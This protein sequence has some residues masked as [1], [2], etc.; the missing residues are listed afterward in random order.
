MVVT[1]GARMTCGW[2]RRGYRDW[3]NI[4][5]REATVEEQAAEAVPLTQFGR[6]CVALD[7]Q[8]MPASF[9]QAKGRVAR[10]HGTHQDRLIKK[11]RRLGI[12]DDAA[13]NQSLETTYW[14]A[15]NARFAQPAVAAADFHRATPSARVLDRV[16]RRE[17]TRTVS[18]DWV[19]R[20][21]NRAVQLPRQ[22]GDAPARGR[23]TVCEWEHGRVAIE[24]RGRVMRWTEITG[25]VGRRPVPVLA[26]PAAPPIGRVRKPA[27]TH[28]WRRDSREGAPPLWQAAK[29]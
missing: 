16:F 21:R 20:Y 28:P 8:V 1:V 13:A 2:F 12:A 18:Q 3:K 7:I 11:L 5:V 26:A 17:E 22:S 10:N 19:V 25:A 24:Y 27:A 4:Y 15:H 14:A 29:S 6:M 9:P 23:V